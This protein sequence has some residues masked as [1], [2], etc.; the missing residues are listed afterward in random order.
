MALLSIIFAVLALSFLIFI[1]EFGH[2]WMARRV[3]M[4]V[5][6]FSI[7]FGKAIYSWKRGDTLWQIGWIPFGGYVKI[8][9]SEIDYEG[10]RSGG[11]ETDTG[12]YRDPY[13]IPDGMF[14]R[15]PLDRIKVLL[16][17]PVANLL[18]AF[19]AF[20]VMWALGGREKSF[21]E[22][23]PIV[24]W[25]DSHSELY[26]KG[27]RPGDEIT[28]YNGY[29]FQSNKDH[30]YAPMTSGAKIDVKGVKIN[31]PSEEKTPFDY[32]VDV[33]PH[34]ASVRSGI[35]TSGIL[36]SANYIIYDT[37]SG[38]KPNPLPEGSPMQGSGIQYGDRIFWVDGQLIF[39]GQ[40]L[41]SIL[42]EGR[43]LL[44]IQRNG[45]LLLRHVPRVEVQEL[46]M[47]S[48][49]KDELI[50]W[51]FEARL[52]TMKSQKLIFIPYNL[53]NECVVEGQLQFIDRENET[54]AFPAQLDSSL[55]EPLH[56]GDKI[57][58]V[59]GK[60][61]S[62]AY[63]L[64]ADLQAYRALVIVERNPGLKDS[65][66][67]RSAT[68]DFE[69]QV[70]AEALQKIVKSIGSPAPVT[71]AGDYVLLKTIK[72]KMRSEMVMNA[73]KQA[74]DSAELVEKKKEIESIEDPDKRHQAMTQL[75]TYER[76]LLL[77]LPGVQDRKVSYNPNPVEL[78]ANVSL[79]IWRTVIALFSGML[80]PK[81]ISGPVGIVQ[82]VQENSAAG[83]NE[84][85]F[86]L[87]AISVNLGLLNLLPIPVL[88][89][90]SIIMHGYELVTRRR[91]NP[92]ILEKV[93]VPFAILL[94]CL[95]VFLTFN[96]I[97][98]I[99]GGFLKL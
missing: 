72:P 96:D 18:F 15:P 73:E 62:K 58:A 78:F 24:G 22:F 92:K 83:L 70:N 1:H 46:K 28:S 51:Q 99:F 93:I 68:E 54:A 8:A 6:V 94:I 87:G 42:N 59:D 37:L 63:E 11:S 71:V 89:G 56:V 82:V 91:L 55:Q 76:Q 17:G 66:S 74:W 79:E 30:L 12:T 19:L 38:G 7:G 69:K 77:G 50:D 36:N 5:E 86:W 9:G 95:F 85:L 25:V 35:L 81:W 14:G 34:P 20:T 29:S 3:G 2:Y 67:W 90:G 39:S 65:I 21:S 48:I 33:Y 43:A 52:N 60:V 75:M 98:R 31:Y 27:I 61:I 26:A 16:A 49:V 97:S 57:V 45:E 84:A 47:D 10:S 64:L 13:D 53:N 80:S 40:Q 32:Q 41:N 44:T 88:D 23:T 4:R